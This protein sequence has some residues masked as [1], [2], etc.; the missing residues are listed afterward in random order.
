MQE[1]QKKKNVQIDFT[2]IRRNRILF[3]ITSKNVTQTQCS[4]IINI[5]REREKK[6][7]KFIVK[8]KL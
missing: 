7:H 5:S 4:F 1:N 2:G 6:N 3:E 8:C